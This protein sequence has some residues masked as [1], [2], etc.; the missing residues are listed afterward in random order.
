MRSCADTPEPGEASLLSRSLYYARSAVTLLRRV[1]PRRRALA[2]CLGLNRGPVSIELDTGCHF[3]V[4]TADDLWTVKETCL[5]R[6]YEQGGVGVEDGWTVLDAGAGLGDFAVSVARQ[7]PRCEVLA[8]EPWPEAY[9][10]L[11]EN[12]A[13][14]G[15][16][17]VRAFPEAVA[18]RAGRLLL[19]NPTGR[20]GRQ[21]STESIRE[22]GA[23]VEAAAITLAEAVGRSRGGRCDFLKLD[24][25]GAE[26][27]ILLS[28]DAD[29]LARIRH[30]AMEYH[31]AVTPHTHEELVAH[32]ERNG[33]AV[34]LAGS[35]V[36]RDLGFLY[37]GNRRWAAAG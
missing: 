28:A 26:Y 2:V 12:V 3:R 25:E 29:T 20:S 31:D 8:F 24:C 19:A 5:D 35:P 22:P 9:A 27:D 16:S 7:R 4:L 17:N 15:V 18:G 32:F 36:W 30:I 10:V 21:R 6:V 37:A 14:N 33:F 23:G 1:R 13:S 34:R 11:A